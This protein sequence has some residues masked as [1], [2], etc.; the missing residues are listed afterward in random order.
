MTASSS[1]NDNFKPSY[2]RLNGSRGDGWCSK[3]ANGND[4]W[5]QIDF[6]RIVQVCAVATQGGINGNEWTTDFKLSFSTDT[7]T[8]ITYKDGNGTEVVR[9]DLI[10]GKKC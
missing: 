8:W 5:L 7:N 10:R 3:T 9:F 2:G 4:D 6:G 1:Y